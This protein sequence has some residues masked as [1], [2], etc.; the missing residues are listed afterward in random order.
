MNLTQRYF[1]N[2]LLLQRDKV[3]AKNVGGD[4][5]KE[6]PANTKKEEVKELSSS[7]IISKNIESGFSYLF[8]QSDYVLVI[9]SIAIL[10]V[11]LLTLRIIFTKKRN[12]EEKDK[13]GPSKNSS[14]VNKKDNKDKKTN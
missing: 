6:I 7:G 10:Y 8:N 4:K 11:F 2:N 13:S 3:N 1:I 12:G 9:F 5:I 14:K